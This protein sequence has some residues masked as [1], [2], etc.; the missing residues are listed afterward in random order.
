MTLLS[1]VAKDERLAE[2]AELLALALTRLRA[3]KSREFSRPNGESS[4]DCFGHQSGHAH[5]ETKARSR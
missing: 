4:L 3:R 5:P 2:I 1:P